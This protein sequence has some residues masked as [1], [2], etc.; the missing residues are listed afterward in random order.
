[1]LAYQ[2]R[3]NKKK[4]KTPPEKEELRKNTKRIKIKNIRML[5]IEYFE[6]L[7]CIPGIGTLIIH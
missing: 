3:E 6:V 7:L 2:L 4:K 5:A 1:M